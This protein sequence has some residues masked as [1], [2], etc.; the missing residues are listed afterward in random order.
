M[1]VNDLTRPKIFYVG[2]ALD[3][4]GPLASCYTA[5]CFHK[6]AVTVARSAAK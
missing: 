2:E 6:M 4:G 1:S 5:G 3:H